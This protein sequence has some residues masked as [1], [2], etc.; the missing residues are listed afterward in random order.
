VFEQMF[1]CFGW[2]VRS[3]R[4]GGDHLI[5]SARCGVAAA[6]GTGGPGGL[7]AVVELD[8]HPAPTHRAADFGTTVAHRRR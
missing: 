8:P 7:G 3:D 1:D 4:Q 5:C 6:S 2:S